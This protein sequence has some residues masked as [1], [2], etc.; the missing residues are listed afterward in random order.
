[1]QTAQND[2]QLMGS[3][4]WFL[5]VTA[6]ESLSSGDNT[7]AVPDGFLRE[8]DDIHPMWYYSDSDSD[9]R[10]VPKEDYDILRD[11]K[12]FVTP[13]EPKFYALVGN[14]R[15]IFPTPDA[16][17]SVTT[18]Y[19]TADQVLSSNIKN[20]W[21]TYASGLL[22]AE[23]GYREARVLRDYEAANMFKMDRDEALRQ[24]VIANA[25]RDAAGML[26]FMGGHA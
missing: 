19:Y 6:S 13:G 9:W 12:D 10:P 21:T 26:R 5:L 18:V 7:L 24:L 17:Y 15:I 22:M 20:Q 16:A 1:M 2:L 11:N 14:N 8:A 4:P 25:A 3:L 23:T